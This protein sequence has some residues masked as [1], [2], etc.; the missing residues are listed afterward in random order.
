M[1]TEETVCHRR[2]SVTY[3]NAPVTDIPALLFSTIPAQFVVKKES[4][5]RTVSSV[6]D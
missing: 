1:V 5:G 2:F 6:M 4:V 3:V